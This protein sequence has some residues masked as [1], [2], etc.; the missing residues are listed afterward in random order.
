MTT[1]AALPNLKK[2]ANPFAVIIREQ[3]PGLLICSVFILVAVLGPTLTPY[4]P[5]KVVMSQR[6]LGLSAL[7]PFGTDDYGRDILTRVIWGA[8]I[9]ASVVVLATAI[10]V[11]LGVPLGLI[12]GYYGTVFDFIL[13]R[14]IDALQTFPPVL[15]AI[16]IAAVL[17]PSQL[18]VI[19]AVGIAGTANIARMA[20]GAVLRV[21][22]LQ[23]VEASHAIGANDLHILL[24]AILPNC[25]S[26]LIIQVS[27]YAPQAVLTEAGLSFL[28]LGVQPPVAS[29]GN[30]LSAAKAY[31]FIAPNYVILVGLSISITII[32]M[33][34]LG[35]G[36]RVSL[37]PQLYD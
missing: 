19:M 17:G 16:A 34:L 7:H 33:N 20:R 18:T 14:V 4:N 5:N 26:P 22:E 27:Y 21:R 9:S 2:R 31:L 25:I 11:A 8:R 6:L 37:D 10:S 35:D 36:L 3:A 15:L 32:G 23:Y 1:V 24:K 12:A 13:S 30:M 28:G 29:W